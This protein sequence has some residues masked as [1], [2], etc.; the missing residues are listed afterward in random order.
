MKCPAPK[1]SVNLSGEKLQEHLRTC[2]NLSSLQCEVCE[3]TF[4]N[5]MS[6]CRHKKK[7]GC[8]PPDNPSRPWIESNEI[9]IENSSHVSIVIDKSSTTNTYN[10]VL[11]PPGKTVPNSFGCEDIDVVKDFL[12]RNPEIIK[13]AESEGAVDS[14]LWLTTHKQFPENDN[15]VGMYKNGGD[16]KVRINGE[17]R[18]LWTKKVYQKMIENNNR[19]IASEELKGLTTRSIWRNLGATTRK[20]LERKRQRLAKELLVN[21]MRSDLSDTKNPLEFVPRQ[22]DF[23]LVVDYSESVDKFYKCFVE[24]K[25]EPTIPRFVEICLPFCTSAGLYYRTRWWEVGA[26]SLLNGEEISVFRLSTK[27]GVFEVLCERI[28]QFKEVML[29]DHCRKLKSFNQETID[30]LDIDTVAHGVL[31]NL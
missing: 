26:A 31:E 27:N 23:P 1:C 21:K 8:K 22:Q 5:A 7:G 18:S 29:Y 15:I 2:R 10:V 3:A 19:L 9:K 12:T 4:N 11:A 6:K 13:F 20:D 25:K 16:V 28:C 24:F 30:A 17:E 14:T